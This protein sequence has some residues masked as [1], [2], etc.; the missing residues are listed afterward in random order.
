LVLTIDDG[1]H[2]HLVHCVWW[3]ALLAV[4]DHGG[5]VER[6]RSDHWRIEASPRRRRA[7]PPRAS[8]G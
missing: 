1:L 3:D 6:R 8:N 2:P 7:F 5:D 4:R